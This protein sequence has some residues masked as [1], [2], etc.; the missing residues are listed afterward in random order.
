[1]TS[2]S[3]LGAGSWG[4]AIALLL[5]RNS[6][7]TILWG[8]NP[9]HVAELKQ[10][11]CN[12]RYLP[13]IVLPDNLIVEADLAT[14]IQN[15]DII[16]IAVPSHAVSSTL[17]KIKPNLAPNTRIAWASK[18]LD[19]AS[20]HL[21]H[22]T[23]YRSLGKQTSVA[24]I[25]GPTFATEVAQ[26]LPTAITV[27]SP[28]PEFGILM[29]EILHNQRF[30][31]YTSDDI[32]GVQLGG[33]VKNVLAIATGA[34][35][36]L[37]FGANTRSAL[38]TRGLAE[39]MRLGICMGA[40]QET[41]MGLAGLGDI[42]LT[43]TDNQSRNR[44]LGLGLGKGRSTA[45]IIGEIGQEVEGISAAREIYKLAKMLTLEMPIT[46]QVYK[47]L[48]EELTPTTA[49][50]NLLVREQKTEQFE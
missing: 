1:M 4:S 3:V 28:Q 10:K 34:A 18:G 23:V 45:E 9:D 32:I 16:I 36:G 17:D 50:Q 8:H 47:V 46:E 43:C 7:S 20:G 44:R 24:V 19:P 39:L 6:H 25:S 33:A 11:R 41:L 31:V 48:Y 30:R 42:V 38:V 22:E 29:S 2:I 5:A 12:Q 27:A 13:G 35:D 14:A 21:L 37:G 15:A 49:V 40:K 26:N